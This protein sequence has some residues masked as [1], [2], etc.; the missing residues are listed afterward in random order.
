MVTLATFSR[1]TLFMDAPISLAES[2][3]RRLAK[4]NKVNDLLFIV[5]SASAN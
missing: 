1:P 3:V 2:A 4:S 5:L